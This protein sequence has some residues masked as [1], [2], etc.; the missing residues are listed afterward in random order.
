MGLKVEL[1]TEVSTIFRS[2]WTERDGTVVPEDDSIKLSNDGVNLDATVLYADMADS[3]AL[4]DQKTKTFAAEIYKTYL[5]CAAKIIAAEGGTITAYDGDRIMAV[6]IG[7]SKNTSAVRSALKI[8]YAR[9]E[10][11]SPSLRRYYPASNYSPNHVV[12]VDTSKLFVAK[13]GIRGSN[14]LVW[15]GHAA[16]HA[17][18]LTTL[19]HLYPTYITAEV[20]RSMHSSVKFTNGEAMWTAFDWNNQPIYG[21][22]WYWSIV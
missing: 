15:V 10:I 19:S 18:K 2:V 20:Y 13:T 6:Y 17:A 14:D 22:A 1:E 16:N 8:N 11:V 7:D 3:T 9:Q 21:S 5:H 12:G 4:V